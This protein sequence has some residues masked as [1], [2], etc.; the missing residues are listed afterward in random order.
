MQSS[1]FTVLLWNGQPSLNPSL[2][3]CNSQTQPNFNLFCNYDLIAE[4]II[5]TDDCSSTFCLF[6]FFYTISSTL[7]WINS[8][9]L[10]ECLCL[11]A[12]SAFVIP[13][14]F[15]SFQHIPLMLVFKYSHPCKNRKKKQKFFSQKVVYQY[16]NQFQLSFLNYKGVL[17]RM[18]T[19]Y[20]MQEKFEIIGETGIWG[21]TESLLEPNNSLHSCISLSP[22]LQTQPQTPHHSHITHGQYLASSL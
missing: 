16:N 11:I 12:L 9:P 4:N 20:S 19:H 22:I 13:I 2:L 3:P 5:T 17:N 21:K 15:C 7:I 1:F 6:T 10:L 8:I 18:D 14:L